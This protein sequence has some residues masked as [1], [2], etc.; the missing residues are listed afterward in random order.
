MTRTDIA[1]LTTAATI[2]LIAAMIASAAAAEPPAKP[3]CIDT[4]ISYVARP[5]NA[6]EIWVQNA[7][8]QKKPPVRVSTSCH[9]VQNA[10]GFGLSAQFTCL[11]LGDPVIATTMGDRQ[12]CVVTKVQAYAPA[13]GD[14][15]EKK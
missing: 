12:A 7:L 9:H 6:N 8:G 3:S 15:P 4:K 5:L 1:I 13:E 14:L 10:I 2:A 11:G